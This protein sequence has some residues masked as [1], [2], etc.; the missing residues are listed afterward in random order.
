MS[1]GLRYLAR[2]PTRK[3]MT[4]AGLI[5]SGYPSG[6]SEDPE[7]YARKLSAVDRC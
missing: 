3:A 4:A 6:G 2:A 1:K 5:A 7:T